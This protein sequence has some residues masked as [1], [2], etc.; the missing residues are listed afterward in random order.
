M[1]T[2]NN[3]S[4]SRVG[5]M[6]YS[7][8]GIS[9]FRLKTFEDLCSHMLTLLKH[10]YTE[11][12]SKPGLF[13]LKGKQGQCYFADMRGT[14]IV[15]IW[16]DPQPL[17]YVSFPDAMPFWLRSRLASGE[18]R[19]LGICRVSAEFDSEES[20]YAISAPELGLYMSAGVGGYC[21]QCG[22]D[23]SGDG[24]Y[25]SK[26]CRLA[27]EEVHSPHC[28]V[29]HTR[30]V[31]G[32]GDNHHINYAQDVTILVCRSCHLKIHR[33]SE[34]GQYRPIDTSLPKRGSPATPPPSE[35]VKP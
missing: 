9:I 10:G 29:C 27:F 34:L 4:A 1:V 15:P 3:I 12:K 6:N 35:A 26:E 22:K 20:G 32:Q 33:G 25:C 19:R 11:A 5:R 13:Y 30:L 21:C 18:Y 7:F 31:F 16:S 2:S 17:F 23:F 28:S 8:K 24:D 14:D